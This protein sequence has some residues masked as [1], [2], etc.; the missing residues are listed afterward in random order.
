MK[1]INTQTIKVYTV[2]KIEKPWKS[3]EN[4]ETGQSGHDEFAWRHIPHSSHYGGEKVEQHVK[5]VHWHHTGWKGRN[6][7]KNKPK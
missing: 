5:T 7:V 2:E 1:K 4:G 6:C 3:E